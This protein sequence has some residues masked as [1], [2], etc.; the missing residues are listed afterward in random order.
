MATSAPTR[1]VQTDFSGGMF[2]SMAPELI[3]DNGLFDVT[4]GLLDEN[5]SVTQ[6]GGTEWFTAP[7]EMD[8]DATFLWSGWLSAGRVLLIGNEDV[9]FSV[10]ESDGSATEVSGLV[11]T[12]GARPAV[13]D[14]K[15]YF[16][17]GK[18]F[19]G[20][21]VGTA[22]HASDHY[23]VCGNRLLYVSGNRVYFSAIGDATTYD[24]TDY[25][26]PPAGVDIAGLVAVRDAAAI[27][28]T[29]GV[30]LI[31]NMSYDLTDDTGA[32]VQRLD[33]YSQELVAWGDTG[34]AGWQGGVIVPGRDAVWLMQV[35][36]A[37]D[38]GQA[39]SR[40]SDQISDLYRNYVASGYEPGTAVVFRGHYLLPIVNEG[41]LIDVLVCNLTATNRRG[42]RTF[43]WSH[44]DG[45]GKVAHL[46]VTD[47]QP[48]R[49]FGAQGKRMLEAFYFTAKAHG[50]DVGGAEPRLDL[51]LRDYMTG[52]LN[53][54]T[55]LKI[56]VAYE[57]VGGYKYGTEWGEFDWGET[58]WEGA[59]GDTQP[60]IEA[61]YGSN[62][63]RGTQWGLFDWGGADWA[64]PFGTIFALEGEAP[65][66]VAA[67]K[68]FVWWVRKKARYARFRLRAKGASS[69]LSIRS[70]EVFVR[71][72]GRI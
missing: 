34:I 27:L 23:A 5:G 55:V 59:P 71:D 18:T 25:H 14:G 9:V 50:R 29:E 13:M 12:A 24:T 38:A 57:L 54:N 32:P 53:D 19:D 31:S 65:V 41:T 37:S 70:V 69:R 2:R 10:D 1:K 43:A 8:A 15:M 52:A 48:Q 30:W 22:T 16:P 7:L 33:R 11:A 17:G 20:T 4:N 68:P 63:L 61:W 28:T 72:A 49:L 36:V 21:T 66:D 58:Y 3:P 42:Q 46:A 47:E 6:R 44:F 40:I 26:A 45:R 35:G 56:R 51:T 64:F 67:A 60:V 39:F 62:R